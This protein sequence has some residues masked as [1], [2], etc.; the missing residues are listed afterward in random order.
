MITCKLYGGLGNQ[1]FQI[2]ACIGFS[3]K[4]M[5][6]YGIPKFTL[7][8]AVWKNY[9]RDRLPSAHPYEALM[10]VLYREP[11]HAYREIPYYDGH[12][13]I[14]GYFQSYGYSI[15]LV[16]ELREEFGFANLPTN[17]GFISI[18][19]RRGDYLLY[20]DKHPV[21]TIEYLRQAVKKFDYQEWDFVIFSDD[22]AWCELK[23]DN[24]HFFSQ[25]EY[26]HT[27][28]IADKEDPLMDLKQMSM[29]EHQ[30]ISNSTYSWWAA[31]LND[32]RGK[33]IV[34]PHE[35]N[36]FG[37]SNKHLDVKDLIPYKWNRIKF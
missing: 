9:F 29:C 37:P 35:D 24:P 21:V 22:P 4:W 3:K 8:E 27:F 19:V 30:I 12:F 34:T 33:I 6:P 32:N 25:F 1:M 36:W 10:Y 14:D 18:H 7:N 15:G 2:A 11:S 28:H 26:S 17:K 20:P 16:K 13:K 31:Y 5:V 23:I